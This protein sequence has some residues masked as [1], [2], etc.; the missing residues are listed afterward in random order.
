MQSAIAYFCLADDDEWGDEVE[1]DEEGRSGWGFGVQMDLLDLFD[2]S[3]LG[4]DEEDRSYWGFGV[5][6]ELFDH[7][8]FGQD[9]LFVDKQGMAMDS[10]GCS[11]FDMGEADEQSMG[12]LD[13]LPKVGG[14]FLAGWASG[15]LASLTPSWPMTSCPWSRARSSASSSLSSSVARLAMATGRPPGGHGGSDESSLGMAVSSASAW[16]EGDAKGWSVDEGG[17]PKPS[18]ICSA[19][20]PQGILLDHE[21]SEQGEHDGKGICE[22]AVAEKLG[23]WQKLGREEEETEHKQ[24]QH[25]VQGQ[26]Q[27]S[28]VSGFSLVASCFAVAWS[29]A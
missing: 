1:C 11:Y 10:Q 13:L 28:R 20:S 21:K 19:R 22:A 4:H 17:R 26:G 7:S 2:H 23:E 24:G 15:W 18:T 3:Y 25:A 29:L 16:G 6:L 12:E 14:D 9:A 8:Y 27:R 5:E